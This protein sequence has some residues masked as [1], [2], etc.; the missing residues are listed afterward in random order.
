[1]NITWRYWN[2]VSGDDTVQDWKPRMGN[3]SGGG[4]EV[5]FQTGHVVFERKSPR[6]TFFKSYIC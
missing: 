5:Q 6:K 2:R 3:S 1:M 4:W